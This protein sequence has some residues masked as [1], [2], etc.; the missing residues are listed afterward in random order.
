MGDDS[1]E[2]LSWRQWLLKPEHP[3]CQHLLRA[4]TPWDV[5][6]T[7]VVDGRNKSGHDDI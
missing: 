1:R 3:S 5:A 4:S 6:K 7:K 2:A